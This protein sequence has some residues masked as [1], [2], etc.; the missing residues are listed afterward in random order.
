MQND[1]TA[2]WLDTRPPDKAQPA[3]AGAKRI[4]VEVATGGKDNAAMQRAKN[5]G[6]LPINDHNTRI[7]V[8]GDDQ[9]AVKAV[10]DSIAKKAFHNVVLF[11]GTANELLAATK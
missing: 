6:T 10:A 9:Q 8:F 11:A 4:S 1:H 2:V 5:D 7:I 3:L